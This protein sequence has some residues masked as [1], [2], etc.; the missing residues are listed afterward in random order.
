MPRNFFR[1]IEVLFPILD[2]VLRDW[3]LREYLQLQLAD[4]VKARMS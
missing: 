4:N 3:L 1:R 2:G